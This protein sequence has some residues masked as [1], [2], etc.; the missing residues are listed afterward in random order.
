M[1]GKNPYWSKKFN[2]FSKSLIS[3]D[4]RHFY[5][6]LTVR[7]TCNMKS[8]FICDRVFWWFVSKNKAWWLCTSLIAY[9]PFLDPKKKEI[10]RGCEIEIASYPL[11]S[12]SHHRVGSWTSISRRAVVPG[13]HLYRPLNSTPAWTAHDPPRQPGKRRPDIA[14][15]PASRVLRS[16]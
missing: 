9:N 11:A 14:V 16:Y 2:I 15:G 6:I 1:R 13:A 7:P 5:P 3:T 8:P 4:K 12:R 10:T